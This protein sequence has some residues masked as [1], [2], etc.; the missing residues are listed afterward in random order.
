M[1]YKEKY[2]K[3]KNKY[4]QIKYGGDRNPPTVNLDHTHTN[5]EN[6]IKNLEEK[7][8]KLINNKNIID[9]NNDDD[10]DDKNKISDKEIIDIDNNNLIFNKN[11]NNKNNISYKEI[12]DKNKDNIIFNKNEDKLKYNTLLLIISEI[13]RKY[14]NITLKN[15]LEEVKNALINNDEINL[16]EIMKNIVENN[17][18]D[19]NN[20][21]ELNKEIINILNEI[22]YYLNNINIKIKFEKND[23]L[24]KIIDYIDNDNNKFS[25]NKYID[26][27]FELNKVSDDL[28]K[29]DKSDEFIETFIKNNNFNKNYYNL[30]KIHKISVDCLNLYKCPFYFDL[31]N[32]T[33][34]MKEISNYKSYVM[35]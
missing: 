3:Y 12:V 22:I 34:N 4:I 23:E 13:N 35:G 15:Y 6:K 30:I 28:Y 20:L 32:F 19:K 2:L 5:L 1:D 8:E 29:S 33:K 18:K 17:I 16:K 7:L 9:I 14:N 26:F 10:N 31:N 24:Q 11:K 21:E 25:D 27:L